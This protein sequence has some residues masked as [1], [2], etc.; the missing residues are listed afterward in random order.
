MIRSVTAV[1]DLHKAVGAS[2][3]ST[4]THRTLIGLLWMCTAVGLASGARVMWWWFVPDSVFAGSTSHLW[5]A[6]A[7]DFT[8]G[9]FYRPLLSPDGYGGIRYM[10]LL[11]VAHGLLLGAGV[12]MIDSGILLMQTS[13]L[14]A[15]L[16]LGFALR[17]SGVPARLAVPLAGTV[18][19]TV[20]FQQYCTDL[21]ADYLAAAFAVAA[22]GL[23]RR[24]ANRPRGPWLAAAAV[25]CVLAGLTKVTEVAVAA[26]IVVWLWVEGA[27]VSAWRFAAGTA[28]LWAIGMGLVQYA[29][30]GAFFESFFATASGGMTMGDA[31]NAWPHFAREVVS[32]PFVGAPFALAGWCVYV[33]A[34]RRRIPLAHLYLVTIALVTLAIFASP[35]T[36]A[37]QLVELH[38]ASVLAVG[39]ALASGD[40]S[41]RAAAPVYAAL[42]VMMAAISW[43]VPGIPSVMATL[44]AEPPHSRARVQAIHAEFLPPGTRYVTTDPI[45]SLIDNERTVLLDDFGLDLAL[46]R[47]APAG[48]DFERRVRRGEIDVIV[49]R[50]AEEFPGDMD[51]SDPRFAYYLKRFWKGSIGQRPM[52]RLLDTAYQVRAVRQPFV[53]FTKR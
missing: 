34:R 46:R 16:A 53:V 27:R 9:E 52:S 50:G 45:I 26:P 30:T 4:T 36:V 15:A 44:R 14:T 51:A 31:W 41:S 10:P 29:S 35:G 42:A 33:A 28:A 5:I 6:L 43:P 3:A 11:F 18:W 13:V 40:L 21:R 2:F 8:H 49:L 48:L 7:W 39:V 47:G 22:I 17:A 24:S 38:L 25:A 32:E 23:A 20:V 19:C 12:D 37:N 1:K